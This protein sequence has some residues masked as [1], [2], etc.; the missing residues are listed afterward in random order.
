MAQIVSPQRLPLDQGAPQLVH[1]L[2]VNMYY[3]L[4]FMIVRHRAILTKILEVTRS[5]RKIMQKY[6]I[7]VLQ[8]KHKRM[9][10]VL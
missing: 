4:R 6:N 9:K 10:L 1:T 7:E 2:L 3:G 8:N 5:L